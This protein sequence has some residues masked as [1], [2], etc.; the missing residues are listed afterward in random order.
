MHS[1]SVVTIYRRITKIWCKRERERDRTSNLGNAGRCLVV[2]SRSWSGGG[3]SSRWS[4]DRKRRLLSRLT[5]EARYRDKQNMA[6]RGVVVK[7]D[8]DDHH[9]K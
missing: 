2:V 5:A 9:E 6:E 3:E 1:T 4:R 7:S 8:G